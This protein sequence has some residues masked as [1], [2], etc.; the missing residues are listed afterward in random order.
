MAPH[1]VDW[2]HRQRD[3]QMNF[4]WDDN[5]LEENLEKHGVDFIKAMLIFEGPV[6]TREDTRKDY[7]ERRFVSIGIVD[8]DCIVVV[9]TSRGGKTRIISAWRGGTDE[10]RKYRN[11]VLGRGSGTL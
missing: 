8:A 9:H 10:R 7:G 6:S 4:E 2:G 3:Y 1:L 5:K 11:D